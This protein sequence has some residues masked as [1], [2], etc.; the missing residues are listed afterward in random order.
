MDQM[1]QSSGSEYVPAP[2]CSPWAGTY[3][4]FFIGD[5]A[6]T[7]VSRPW[8]HH[9]L[10]LLLCVNRE[11]KNDNTSVIVSFVIFVQ[12]DQH[13]VTNVHAAVCYDICPHPFVW[14]P[15][16]ASPSSAPIPTVPLIY[17]TSAMPPHLPHSCA[18]S[19]VTHLM[20][21]VFWR[22]IIFKLLLCAPPHLS[23][24]SKNLPRS[25]YLHPLHQP[26]VGIGPSSIPSCTVP[27]I[28]HT[29][30][31]YPSYGPE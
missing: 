14:R 13:R 24:P 10:R 23:S 26:P 3:V 7:S 30:F 2:V 5:V 6:N 25:P 18:N 19:S 11:D 21:S 15:S 17:T 22:N 20:S 8:S 12:N 29:S 16:S 27:L 4:N 1:L 9:H 31:V 28:D